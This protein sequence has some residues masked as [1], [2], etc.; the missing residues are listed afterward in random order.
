M[1]W[2]G[3]VVGQIQE[4]SHF[5]YRNCSIGGVKKDA[6]M[7]YGGYKCKILEEKNGPSV[8]MW[9]FFWPGAEEPNP[10]SQPPDGTR[11]TYVMLLAL[12]RAQVS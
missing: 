3:L 10:L 8:E 2:K 12:L 4:F 11:H 6:S 9:A 5:P 7:I 1:E